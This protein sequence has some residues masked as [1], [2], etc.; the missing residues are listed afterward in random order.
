M[1]EKTDEAIKGLASLYET[2]NMGDAKQLMT[3]RSAQLNV[4]VD[5]LVRNEG[6]PLGDCA[7]FEGWYDN[8]GKTETYWLVNRRE[9]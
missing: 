1:W 7:P 4:E 3:A 6:G 9:K 5:Q 2:H 8:N